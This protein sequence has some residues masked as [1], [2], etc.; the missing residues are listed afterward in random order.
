MNNNP[1][2]RLVTGILVYSPNLVVSPGKYTVKILFGQGDALCGKNKNS[3]SI[4]LS[5]DF[6]KDGSYIFGIRYFALSDTEC[7]LLQ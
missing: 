1:I 2:I 5:D 4:E 6:A 7:L 3:Q